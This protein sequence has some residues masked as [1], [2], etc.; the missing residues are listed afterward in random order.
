MIG[1]SMSYTKII[2][3]SECPSC[4]S[5]LEQVNNQLFCPNYVDCPAQSSG[6][7][8]NFAKKLKIKGFG[9]ATNSKLGFSHP[10]DFTHLTPELGMEHGLSEHM[11]TK[12]TNVVRAVL[13]KGISYKDFLAACSIPLIG[14]AATDKLNVS[15]I[16]ELTFEKCKSCGLGDKASE[17]LS[18]WVQLDWPAYKPCWESYLVFSNN[19]KSQ[20]N[21]LGVTVVI[22]GKLTDFKNR[23]DATRHLESLGFTV[24][25]TV[26][27]ATDYLIC[28][29]GTTGSSYKKA[30][31]LNKQITTIKYLEDKYVKN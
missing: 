26:S 5:L 30:V 15:S 11:A 17:N 22:T 21:N 19:N 14:S 13:E 3:P 2:A 28:E 4:G 16:E 8:L 23:S 29:D 1:E 7:L 31:Q 12:L 18:E 24:K 27:K 6:K 9:E 20:S 25:T 10:N